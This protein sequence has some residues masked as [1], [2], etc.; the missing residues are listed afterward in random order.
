MVSMDPIHGFRALAHPLAQIRAAEEFYAQVDAFIADEWVELFVD[1]PP[2]EDALDAVSPSDMLG[3]LAT[4]GL[5]FEVAAAM[6]DPNQRTDEG[7]WFL[8]FRGGSLDALLHSW[9]YQVMN[10]V[11]LDPRAF[12]E[13]LRWTDLIFVPDGEHLASEANHL[14]LTADPDEVHEIEEQHEQF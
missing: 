3:A 1:E 14:L 8:R 7:F 6:E 13:A 2:D 12:F 11:E 10:A 5:R 4:L 9:A